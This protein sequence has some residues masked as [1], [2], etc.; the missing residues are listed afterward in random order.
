MFYNKII[1]ASN[2]LKYLHFLQNIRKCVKILFLEKQIKT[3]TQ[4][5]NVIQFY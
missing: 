1:F 5:L 3:L 2:D 4:N